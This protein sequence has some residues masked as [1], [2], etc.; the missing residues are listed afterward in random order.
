M[1]LSE[2]SVRRPVFA[3]VVS[4]LLT[5]IGVMALSRLTVRETPNVQPPM[6][7]IDTVYRGASAAVIE[8]KIT[9][10]IENQIAGLEG[11]E[12]LRSSSFDERSR[13]TIEFAL[14]R[15]I[16]SAANDV[17]DRVAR[18][19]QQ[20]PEEAEQ[21]QIAKVD[22]SSEPVMWMALTSAT[23]TQLELTDYSDR[24]LVDRL[25]VVPGVA[26]IRIGGER[27]Y[28]MRVW[29]DRKSLAARQLTVQDVEGSLRQ[30]NIEL[31]AGRIE[32]LEREFT[33]RTDT[34]FRT[35]EDFRQL[36]IGR[37]GD[38]Y[39]VRLGEVA[40]GG[41]GCRRFALGGT[42][43]RQGGREPRHR[44]SVDRQ[45][46]GCFRGHLCGNGRG[47][48]NAAEGPDARYQHRRLRSSSASRF[49]KW[50]MRWSPRCCW[51]WW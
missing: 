32:S 29:L 33:L 7:S 49:S 51:C 45:R 15:D 10:M 1:I 35:P 22:T 46:A 40:S 41:S 28:A 8:S 34:G 31:P 39:L 20:L 4:L 2:I 36:V 6:V 3:M 24:Y 18:V 23:R 12:T 50:S 47:A 5:I 9:Q 37:G 43:R 14:D 27:R 42:H 48:E 19:V 38:G 25:S 21:P 30:E 16:E 13:I 26:T 11:V 44:S 17:R